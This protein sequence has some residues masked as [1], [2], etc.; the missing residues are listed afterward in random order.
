MRLVNRRNCLNLALALLVVATLY[1]A[2]RPRNSATIRVFDIGSART[3][4]SALAELGS[5]YYGVS[6]TGGDHDDGTIF[7]ITSSGHLD[8][9]C[10][11]NHK[12]PAGSRP[13]ATLLA[14]RDG[15]LYGTTS[16][17]G[18]GRLGSLFRLT[19]AGKLT[20]IHQFCL[21]EGNTVLAALTQGNAEGDHPEMRSMGCAP[22]AANRETEPSSAWIPAGS[23]SKSSIAFVVRMAPIPPPRSRSMTAECCLGQRLMAGHTVPGPSSISTRADRSS[24]CLLTWRRARGGLPVRR[25]TLYD[26]AARWLGSYPM[27]ET[28]GKEPSSPSI[29]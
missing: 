10:S 26:W 28:G 16:E 23:T 25:A 9:L 27:V 17:G 12:S 2:G 18:P 14:A 22:A 3:P 6:R 20:V 19:S 7:R 29:Q 4:R 8:F 24:R 1:S 5:A 15:C 21:A 11:L 13:E